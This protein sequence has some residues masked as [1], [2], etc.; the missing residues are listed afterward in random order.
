MIRAETAFFIVD[1]GAVSRVVAGDLTPVKAEMPLKTVG[2]FQFQI[3]GL[4]GFK[5]GAAIPR[6]AVKDGGGVRNGGHGL[7][8][9]VE[10]IG[11]DILSL[12]GF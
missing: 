2:A 9:T 6:G 3:A 10:F 7:E 12:I 11:I 1:K 8:I 4:G 5:Q